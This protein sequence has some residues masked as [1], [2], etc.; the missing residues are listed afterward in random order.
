MIDITETDNHLNN[1]DEEIEFKQTR[2][3]LDERFLST[4]IQWCHIS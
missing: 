3:I 4:V 1:C 2:E